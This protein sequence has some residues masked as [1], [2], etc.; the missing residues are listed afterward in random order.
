MIGNIK[1]IGQIGS[2]YDENGNITTRG[3]EL[4]DV[5][6]QVRAFKESGFDTINFQI[7]SPGGYVTTGEEIAKYMV[8]L[9]TSGLVVNT[10]Q[11]GQIGS[12]AVSLFLEGQNRI[13][14][15]E[16]LFIHNP[17]NDPGPMDAPKAKYFAASLQS[18]KDS[19]LQNYIAKT[20]NP[21]SAL[22]PLMD[23]ETAIPGD[24]A[25][26]LGF[27]TELKSKA[28]QLK[29]S[30][31]KEDMDIKKTMD[32]ISASLKALKALAESNTKA[33]DIKLAGGK[34]A[35]SDAADEAGLV[36]SSI[37]VD[38]APAPDGDVPMEDGRII[39]ISGGKVTA[40]K[41]APAP[42]PPQDSAAQIA[43]LT[44][45]VN[46]L[47][48]LVKGSV[49]GSNKAIT[50]IKNQIKGTHVPAKKKDN[51]QNGTSDMALSKEFDELMKKGEMLTIRRGDPERYK[52][53]Y[54]AKYGKEPVL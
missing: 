31:K 22:E 8:D 7:D 28:F 30:I 40:I 21:A 23:A 12:I 47:A 54:V 15:D 18:S 35:V 1:I 25:V 4:I 43:A 42:A 50:E 16:G 49:E 32:E 36:G 11:I 24:Q 19:L 34:M 9:K 17:W 38:G 26:S 13:V 33:L 45:Q 44:E 2:D 14:T 27:A 53:L 39:T 48:Q 46:A 3:V 20:G 10:E 37:M 51:V 6:T 52:A 5:V 41:P 29:A